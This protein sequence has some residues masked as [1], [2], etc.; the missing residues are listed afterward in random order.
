MGKATPGP[1]GSKTDKTWSA[2][3]LARMAD[4]PGCNWRARAPAVHVNSFVHVISDVHVV[5][6]DH[7]FSV[8]MTPWG[9]SVRAADGKIALCGDAGVWKA[10]FNLFGRIIALL[11][12]MWPL[13][14]R[15]KDE[16]ARLIQTHAERMEF[17]PLR[18]MVN[19]AFEDYADD[20]TFCAWCAGV[21][22]GTD[23]EESDVILARF[24]ERFPL[25]LYPV[26]VDWAERQVRREMFDDATNE[27]RAYLNRVHEQGISIMAQDHDA[28]R[29]GCSRGFL[30]LTSAY[31]EAGARSYSARVLEFAMLLQ[32]EPFWQH[33]FRTEHR[34][35]KEE[36]QVP[37]NKRLDDQWE[38]F[39]KS[40]K[41]AS[42][43]VK[44]C[45]KMFMPVLGKRV[46]TIGELYKEDPGF[47][48]DEGEILQML[49][50]TDNGQFLLV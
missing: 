11:Q 1:T 15:T 24:L 21:A 42:K 17:A 7:V 40:G 22:H 20:E 38:A 3:A 2:G 27:A 34:R 29:D 48:A 31:T 14:A 39:F 45:D 26:Q 4:P 41:G 33:R 13:H 25:S 5:P 12:P 18:E 43:L 50:R 19:S 28:L 35:L 16:Y 36:L 44:R 30:L 46:E 47:R 23:L 32:M 9:S 49:Y 6:S 8:S 10:V 37:A